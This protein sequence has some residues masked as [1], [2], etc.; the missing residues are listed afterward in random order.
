MFRFFWDFFCTNGSDQIL[1][2]G[3]PSK[4]ETIL[5][6]LDEEERFAFEEH[7]KRVKIG[8]K[9]L[10]DQAIEFVGRHYERY[11]TDPNMKRLN[12]DVVERINKWLVTPQ[13]LP[14]K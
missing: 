13:P 3:D 10:L 2:L 1:Y 8:P 7:L 11:E 9:S 14:E 6:A 4:F 5:G 12:R